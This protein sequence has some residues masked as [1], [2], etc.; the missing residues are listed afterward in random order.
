[1]ADKKGDSYMKRVE[2]A[3]KE[4]QLESRRAMWRVRTGTSA[5]AER[6]PPSNRSYSH[7]KN[8]TKNRNETDLY[9]ILSTVDPPQGRTFF[10]RFFRPYRPSLTTKM[11]PL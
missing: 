1:M 3:K 11:F 2:D 10:E 9:L 5:S 8:Q 7:F 4:A 6:T